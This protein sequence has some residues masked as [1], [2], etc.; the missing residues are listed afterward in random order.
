MLS[1]DG[2][3]MSGSTHIPPTGIHWPVGDLVGDAGEQ[4]RLALGDPGVLLGLRAREPV[5]GHRRP[6]A[7]RP[8]RT[9]GCTCAPSRP[10]ATAT[11]CRCGRGPWRRRGGRR[12]RP[13]GAS[14]SASAAR[15]AATASSPSSAARA[16]TSRAR[17]MATR[18]RARR[19]S[20]RASVR[21][22][23]SSTSRSWTSASASA[24]TTTSSARSRRYSSRSPAVSGEP[25]RRRAE[26]REHRVRRRLD[27]E[28]DGSRL[29]GRAATA[30]R[31]GWMPCTGRPLV[32]RTRPSHWKPGESSRNPRSM[33]RLDP[34][35]RPRRRDLAA[36]PE[37]RRAPRR[38]PALADGERRQ[39]RR[40]TARPRRSAAGAAGGRA[41]APARRP[42]G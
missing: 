30:W 29:A 7:P 33:Q 42:R 24:S 15:A 40:A 19:G 18:I 41:A 4:L 36:E 22:T 1:P 12:D 20:S 21:I 39:R 31:R 10:A 2:R 25:E 28:L 6:S 14:T 3:F 32:S 37:P 34:A 23:P 8:R 17:T 26:L 27:D 13:G 16:T 5:V 9:C 11:P 35:A 38:A